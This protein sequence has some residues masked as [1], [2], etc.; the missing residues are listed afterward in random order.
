MSDPVPIVAAGVRIGWPQLPRV[1]QLWVEHLLGGGPVIWHQSQAGGFSPGSADRVRTAG[2]ERAFVK[3]ISTDQ[4]ADSP[5][6]HRCEAAVVRLLG[7]HP[8]IPTLLGT[9]DD[10]RWV[11]LVYVDVEGRPP[12]VPWTEPDIDAT[13]IALRELAD[14]WSP[15]PEQLPLAGR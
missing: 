7:P 11:V 13:M 15:A 1:V 5:S 8:R 2:G 6:I 12:R 10:G 14:S 9:Y 3:A 4:N